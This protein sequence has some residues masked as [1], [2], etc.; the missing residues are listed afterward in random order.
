[1]TLEPDRKGR[2]TG[3]KKSALIIVAAIF[4]KEC[5]FVMERMN[6]M[7]KMER[8]R[9]LLLVFFL[10]GVFAFY[11]WTT[12]TSYRKP[13]QFNFG[14]NLYETNGKYSD[15]RQ[16]D[17]YNALSD[18]F[19]KGQLNL[20]INPRP[21]FLYLSDPYNP[22]LN[23]PYRLHDATLYDGKYYL[24]F[25][26]VPAAVF[27]VPFRLIV[28]ASLPQDFAIAVLGFGGLVWF[29]LLLS[30]LTRTYLPRTPFWLFF[31]AT[32]CAS[33]C[34]VI[35][36][37]ARRPEVYEVAISSGYF[38]LTASL[39]WLISGTFRKKVVLWRLLLGSVFLGLAVGSRYNLI[40]ASFFLLL[41]W[42][43]ILTGHYKYKILRTYKETAVL[44]IPFSICMILLL[45]YNHA[46]F[47]SFLEFGMRYQ[48]AAVDI[49][50]IKFYNPAF[51]IP[52]FYFYFIQPCLV[53]P[54]FPF[55]YLAPVFPL[56]LP[57]G[58]LFAEPVAGIFVT[59]PFL[60]ILFVL[61]LFYKRMA[62]LNKELNL[63]TISF[64]ALGL[65]IVLFISG[66][67]GSATMRYLVDFVWLFL[68]PV[69]LFWFYLNN[70]FQNHKFIRFL[71]NVVM[72][73]FIIYGCVF[74]I[75]ISFTGYLDFL[76][77]MN[78]DIYKS[79]AQFFGA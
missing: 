45:L 17:Y 70:F 55:F 24:Y 25:G 65:I 63:L 39:Y 31:I 3:K 69:F 36:F 38:C 22:V 6:F 73:V 20:L 53:Y 50:A 57:E 54:K 66:V 47:G 42:W 28:Q 72:V 48:L 2:S 64:V 26:P 35:P 11:L 60:N 29:I 30:F 71:I 46:R 61:P 40:F 23:A 58:Y 7:Q 75:F 34:N 52:N 74:N 21:E 59:M 19:L 51:I 76:N 18:A 33:F 41:A 67:F 78:P 44:F 79:I 49:R 68:L 62:Q 13:F 5:S 37:I 14:K 10:S 8:L 77:K 43:K 1:M 12:S 15:S 4:L 9:K 32:V 27:F 16:I 56:I